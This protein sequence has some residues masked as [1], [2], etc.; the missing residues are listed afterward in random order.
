MKKNKK[1]KTLYLDESNIDDFAEFMHKEGDRIAAELKEK[2][3]KEYEAE[4]TFWGR[5][6]ALWFDIF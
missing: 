1:I 6:K 4:N 2:W 5:I 3:R